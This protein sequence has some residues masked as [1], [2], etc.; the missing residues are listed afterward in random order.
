MQKSYSISCVDITRTEATKIKQDKSCLKQNCKNCTILNDD[1]N[2]LKLIILSLQENI[3]QI[4]K[5]LTEVKNSTINKPDLSSL[6]ITEE[7]I[8]EISER[9]KR[10][11]N[12]IIFRASEEQSSKSDQNKLDND[13]AK[14]IISDLGVVCPIISSFRVGRY[15]LTSSRPRPLKIKL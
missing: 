15:D 9:N 14:A 13:L 4:K 2:S 11:H 6:S 5:D 8:N 3:L 10:S 12:F 1:I 7:I